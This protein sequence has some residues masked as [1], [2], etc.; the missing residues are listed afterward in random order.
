MSGYLR[1]F[2]A[3]CVVQAHALEIIPFYDYTILAYDANGKT[4]F[5]T[6]MQAVQCFYVFSGFFMA[7]VLRQKYGRGNLR[8]FYLSR[9][10]RIFPAYWAML[11]LVVVAIAASGM[12][13]TRASSLA[14]SEWPMQWL[15]MGFDARLLAAFSNLCIFGQDFLWMVGFHDGALQWAPFPQSGHNGSSYSL[16][17]PAFTLAIEL[18]FYLIA[19][20]VI[21][22]PWRARLLLL[23]GLGYYALLDHAGQRTVAN[24]YYLFPSSLIFFALGGLAFF[25]RDRRRAGRPVWPDMALMWLVVFAA[26]A[27]TSGGIFLTCLVICLLM[28]Y[29]D[30]FAE[31][32]KASD[33]AG[34]MAYLVY[35]VHYPVML[36][37]AYCLSGRYAEIATLTIC[38]LIYAVVERPK[39]RLKR[40][41]MAAW[42]GAAAR[43]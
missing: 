11:L 3:M 34:D 7:M 6:G 2:L 9:F 30:W 20:F 25:M 42:G 16:N 37:L 38:L 5:L 36:Y 1:L 24:S 4:L 35:I 41:W 17:A 31:E 28:A 19:P 14:L 22:S 8:G 43:D 27:I 23:A 26:V 13:L 39:K 18:T 33:F 32:N 40:R 15:L 10:M 29:V 12:V 21:R